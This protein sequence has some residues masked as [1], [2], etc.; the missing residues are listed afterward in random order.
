LVLFDVDWNPSTD[1]Q[2]MARIHRDG[3]KQPVHIYRFLTSGMMDEKI[4]QRQITKQALADAFMVP[5]P[6]SLPLLPLCG[7]G[8]VAI[9]VV[10]SVN[11]RTAK[12]PVE[13]VSPS[14][15]YGIY[16][17]SII[18]CVTPTISSIV[19]APE[20]TLSSTKISSPTTSPT[21]TTTGIGVSTC[22]T[23]Q[24]RPEESE[25]RCVTSILAFRSAGVEG[26][27]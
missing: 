20:T 13:I 16:L 25:I 27:E 11:S 23:I 17:R 22:L 2:A 12:D 8:Y 24:T 6:F 19:P 18:P 10:M 7:Y 15:N 4:F 14:K 5:S 26:K 9:A 21:T 3:Q 1:T